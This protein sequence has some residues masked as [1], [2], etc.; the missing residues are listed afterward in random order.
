LNSYFQKST[1]AAPL[2]V[3]RIVFGLLLFGS[4]VRFWLKGW[5]YDL[6]IKP[7]YFFPFFGFD[8]VKPLGE[9]TY[10]LFAICAIASLF[11]AAGFFYR[12]S[13]IA[14]FVSFTYVELI[15]KST[16][17]NHYYFISMI[18]LLMIFLPANTYFSVD[19]WRDKNLRA[20]QIP[21]WTVDSIKL[22]VC[23]LY[24]FAGLAK[25]NSD[26]LLEAQPLRIWLPAKN[27]FPLIGS[28]FNHVWVAY[29]FSWA[30]CLYDLSIPFL[31]LTRSTRLYAYCT[32]IIF[33]SLTAMLFPIGMFPYI[34]IAT[35]LIFFS[36]E[37][38]Q[39][40][41]YA[42]ASFFKISNDFLNNEKQYQY[43][44]LISRSIVV[45]FI[46][47]FLVQ[48]AL[49]FRYVLYP[50]ELF[51]TEEGYR[52]SWRVMLMEKA[53]YA[54]FTVKDE[55]G[56]Y[57]VVENKDFLTPLQEKVVATQPDMIL[58][59]AHILSEH[60]AKKGFHYPQVYVDSYVTLNGRFGKPLI[61]PHTN[62]AQQK[63]S[64]GHKPWILTFNDE[65]KGF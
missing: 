4:I 21:K 17:L 35:A 23:M 25:V 24:V 62:L 34:M 28:L 6:Y 49:P 16:Y 54:Q 15:D 52:F 14:L 37:F 27:D 56:K 41:L 47:F 39:K 12:F 53:G 55:T 63:E 45:F 20:S 10:I 43:N 18:S 50:G 51:W 60:Y 30:G 29:V 58:Q 31:L 2:T 59:Y 9:Y 11:V 61:D 13:A 7:K 42:M 19:A 5:I 44:K 32:V 8:F 3:F 1:S 65:I 33:H 26:W 48:V 57:S 36:A 38:H 64:F 46:L 40:I 22:F